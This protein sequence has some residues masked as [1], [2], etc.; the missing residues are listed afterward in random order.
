MHSLDVIH[1]TFLIVLQHLMAEV[2]PHSLRLLL[3]Y[4]LL[5]LLLPGLQGRA[6]HGLLRRDAG[7]GHCLRHGAVVHCDVH[8]VGIWKPN[9]ISRGI[10]QADQSS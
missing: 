5:L 1:E 7:A 3:H 2:T 4:S 8:T 9:N 6:R 10:Q